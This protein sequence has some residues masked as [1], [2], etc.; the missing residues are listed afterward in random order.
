MSVTLVQARAF[1]AL[2]LNLLP[3]VPGTKKPDGA[4]LP[5]GQDDRPT[6]KHLQETRNTD[7]DLVAW[8]GNSTPRDAAI[9][10]GQ[11]SG[12]VALDSDTP[13]GEA[14]IQE[15]E[16]A[17]RLPSTP[18]RTRTKDGIH[19]FYRRPPSR[20]LP[21]FLTLPD[22]EK[23]ELKRD[24]QYVV[25]PG[26][27]HPDGPNY[28]A[29]D[30][31][32]SSINSL[33]LFPLEILVGN[34]TSTQ[35]A[36]TALPQ[37]LMKGERNQRLFLEGCRL[38]RMGWA[39]REIADALKALNRERCA[40]GHQ[41]SEHE[42]NAIARSVTRY[43]PAEHHYPLT[44]AGNAEAFVAHVGTQV[45]YDHARKEWM[46]FGP[47]HWH[48]DRDGAINRLAL[49]V[50]RARQALAGASA[51]ESRNERL[52]WL[53]K[54]SESLSRLAACLQL[55]QSLDPVTD[56]GDQ[57]DQDPWL[58]GVTNG[59]IDLQAGAFRAGRPGDCVTL[60][61]PV[62]Y[63]PTSQCARWE[64]FLVEIFADHP[65]LPAYLQRLIGYTLTGHTSE[66]SFWI[67]YG[68]GAN[69]K[70]SLIE[71]LQRHVFGPY[72]ATIP[73]P[74]AHWSDAMSEYQ[75]AA[76]V[77]RRYVTSAEVTRQGRL[78]E[79][80][81]KSLTGGDTI[82]AR[83]PYGRPFNFVPCAKFF[84]RVNEKPQIRDE[85][86]GMWR[87]VKLVPFTRTF[88]PNPALA[89]ELAGEAS[90]ILRW[91]V[92]GCLAWQRDGGLQH[93]PSVLA[94]TEAYR[95]EQDSLTDFLSECCVE[96]PIARVRAGALFDAY[97]QWAERALS[98]R[99]RLSL[100]SFGDRCKTR[101]DS[102]RSAE[103]LSYF[104]IGL[105]APQEA[106]NE[107]V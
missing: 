44:D 93:P 66:Q 26:S 60:V 98:E 52:K 43:E 69:G 21:A 7:D 96:T 67:P 6:W 23:I 19:R 39:E 100:R 70:S 71:T 20:E 83:H 82:N 102:R 91:A 64:Q 88:Q 107:P 89:A 37:T 5:K 58:F 105:K 36:A 54:T 50:L 46:M 77:G 45:R 78:H 59:V 41:L 24:G 90:G 2:G 51:D 84:L 34:V 29:I 27:T 61:A 38:R 106:S 103:G 28:E 4:A 33:P 72:A 76:L 62:V 32:P 48:P 68:A 79:E 57:W 17:G 22:G 13:T 35:P 73:F 74:S 10:L 95:A 87:R 94:A 3:I 80:L 15:Q 53:T 40:G 16:A 63:N 99:D 11:I 12:V 30:P 97:R 56:A 86:H 55:A 31:W 85:S 81:I 47:H 101:F 8:F 104:G 1:A 18:M 92:E 9:V 75:K 65:D 25:A 42:V 14:W 49:D